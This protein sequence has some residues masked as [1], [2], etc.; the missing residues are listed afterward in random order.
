MCLLV[1]SVGFQLVGWPV[2]W[3]GLVGLVWLV[4]RLGG[5]VGW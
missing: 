5:G 3:I 4:G 1:S 2:V